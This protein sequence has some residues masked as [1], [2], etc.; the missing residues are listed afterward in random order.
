MKERN[1]NI[2]KFNTFAINATAKQLI[3]V[4]T[5]QDLV[6]LPTNN[7]V[8]ILGGGSNIIFVNEYITQPILKIENTGIEIIYEDNNN[9]IIE[10]A[11]GEKWS[12]FVIYCA[13]HYYCGLE[14]LA[15]IYGTVGA[16]PVQNIGAYGVEVKDCIDSV[17]VYDMNEKTWKI[18]DNEA[19]KFDYRY[20]RFKY[21]N[22]HELIWKVRFKF[23]KTFV[24]NLSY[25]ALKYVFAT[26]SNQS[27]SP[28]QMCK[29][30]T[31]LRNTKLPNPE[32]KP[33]VGSFFK[34]PIVP[35]LQF[36]ILQCKYP[37][38][39]YFYTPKDNEIKLSA[40][41]I[42]EKA[43]WKGK[44][45]KSVEMYSNQS[46]IMVAHKKTVKASHIIE[47]ANEIMA[48]VKEKFGVSLEIE[49][50]IIN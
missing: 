27:F 17:I 3:H 7:D 13:K 34:N 41:W 21:D 25:S 49:P 12:D 33:N 32:F 18:Y 31:Y 2:R 48:D 23:S 30:V 50:H 14:N 5:E 42:I 39:A 15:A 8:I 4:T 44:V 38:I 36:K 11:A 46:L 26:M 22:K 47:L 28:L 43:G 24:P 37:N 1:V 6:N 19:C 45:H 35:M 20:S 29:M 40:A 10:V 9:I 16:A